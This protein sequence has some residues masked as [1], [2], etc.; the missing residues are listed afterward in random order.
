MTTD[1]EK[2]KKE[3]QN[4]KVL[5]TVD[6]SSLLQPLNRELVKQRIMSAIAEPTAKEAAYTNFSFKEKA[7]KYLKFA[8]STLVGLSLLGG[9]AF[10]AN[11]SKPGDVLFGI[12]KA[13]E[14]IAISLAFSAQSQAE[15]E[16]KFANRRLE[17]LRQIQAETHN[18]EQG[19]AKATSTNSVQERPPKDPGQNQAEIQAEAE[20]SNAITVLTKTQ[21]KLEA[22]GNSNAASSVN[23]TL[24]KLKAK[25]DE[26]N[27][28]KNKKENNDGENPPNN[29]LIN[30]NNGTTTS[31]TDLN[32]SAENHDTDTDANSSQKDNNK[33]ESHGPILKP[34]LPHE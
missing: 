14:K 34:I 22:N 18:N 11:G 8:V 9:T 33:Q 12:K 20:V 32:I 29:T 15:L 1:S 6:R 4:L 3:I 27:K 7:H 26:S 28:K 31:T 21:A 23:E 16:T 2:F 24:L 5:G 30:I 19:G 13:E 17:E 10:A 25:Q